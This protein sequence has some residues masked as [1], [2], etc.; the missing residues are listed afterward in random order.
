M[1]LGKLYGNYIYL[2]LYCTTEHSPRSYNQITIVVL[3]SH[4]DKS[5]RVAVLC[6]D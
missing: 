1:G 6:A 3:S 2:L 4:R 5:V